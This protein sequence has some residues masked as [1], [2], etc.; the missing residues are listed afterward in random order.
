MQQCHYVLTAMNWARSG[1]P[2]PTKP[3]LVLDR[4]AEGDDSP[5]DPLD[6]PTA[7]DNVNTLFGTGPIPQVVMDPR[8][9]E[10]ATAPLTT[11]LYSAILVASDITCGGCDLNNENGDATSTP[12]SDAIFARRDAIEAFFNAGGGIYANSGAEHADGDPTDGPDTYYNFLPIPA[13]GVA[14]SPPFCL[15][16]DGIALGLED[17]SCPDAT[18]HNGTNNDI[19]CCATHNSFAEPPAG[20]PLRVGERDREGSAETLFG[21]GKIFHGTFDNAPPASTATAASCSPTG[22]QPVTVTDASGGSGS[23]AVHFKI[24]GGAEQVAAVDASG[25]AT[26]TVPNGKHTVEF[27]GEDNAGN[28]ETAHHTITVLTDTTTKCA[29]KLAVAGVRRACVTKV[30]KVQ[31]KATSAAGVRSVTV[32]LDGKTVLKTK[33]STFTVKVNAAK[34]KAGRH[35]LKTVVTSATGQKVTSTRTIARCA[36]AK[37]KQKAAPRFTG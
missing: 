18:L 17:Q 23:K 16:A 19:N 27:W 30:V 14:V 9:P 8:S 5:G 3:V 22:F 4:N 6:F 7:L 33:K 11:D 12:D 29:P 13:T 25:K 24:D 28:V 20:S 34:L 31:I 21:E 1:A 2:D 32:S 10:F 35:T 15:T 37:P 26:L 36:A